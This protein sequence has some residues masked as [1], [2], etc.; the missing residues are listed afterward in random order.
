MAYYMNLIPLYHRHLPVQLSLVNILSVCDGFVVKYLN[1][2]IKK[3]LSIHS[4]NVNSAA[5]WLVT[6]K[7]DGNYSEEIPALI[8]TVDNDNGWN[9]VC[10]MPFILRYAYD[11]LISIE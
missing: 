1:I 7:T 9:T 8:P 4:N 10:Y 2:E 5:D 3:A 11:T 6:E